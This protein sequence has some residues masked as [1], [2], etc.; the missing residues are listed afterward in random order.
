MK[1][2]ILLA[3][4]LLGLVALAHLLRIILRTEVKVGGA[5]VPMWV[6]VIACVVAGGV[7]VMLWHER[8][9]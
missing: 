3:T 9:G 1:P 2:A 6:S 8:R 7:A 5:L 4:V